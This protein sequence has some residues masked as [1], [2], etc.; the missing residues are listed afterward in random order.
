MK[1]FGILLL[2]CLLCL[3]VCAACSGQEQ[4]EGEI[5]GFELG[6]DGR[7]ASFSI[8]TRSGKVRD[9]SMTEASQVIAF[10]EDISG[11]GFQREPQ[12][13]ASVTVDL[14]KGAVRA[15]WVRGLVERNAGT[16]SDGTPLDIMRE[17]RRHTY[18]LADGTELLAVMDSSG[19]DNC[20][21]GGIESFDDL[22]ETAKEK[23][24]AYYEAQGIL[25][26][27]EAELERAYAA[28]QEEGEEYAC[29]T[30]EQNTSPTA[31]SSQVMYFQTSVY[32]PLGGRTN[33]ELR[34]GAAFDRETGEHIENLDLF[35]C[36]EE[37]AIEAFLDAGEV[38]TQLLR[39]EMRAAFQPEYLVFF[40]NSLQILFLQE[41][42][43]SQ[44]YAYCVSAEY[45]DGLWEVLHD[46]AVPEKPAVQ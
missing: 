17:S 9:F 2:L 37:E 40:S 12:L 30:L 34:L 46:W 43:P 29:R 35:A 36:S 24:L 42:L 33:H 39:T 11:D 8:R 20:Y 1:R 28:W 4:V 22:S 41:T 27:E 31:S 10:L 16:L 23:V 15:L 14:E 38:P 25:Y 5:I 7:L 32:L 18:R 45:D 21:V 6:E 13:N 3:G 44:E 19:P 26:D